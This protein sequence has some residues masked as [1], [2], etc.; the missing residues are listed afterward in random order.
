M[1]FLLVDVGSALAALL[2]YLAF[3]ALERRRTEGVTLGPA[4]K[5]RV[6]R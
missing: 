2:A 6:S 5:R 1:G 4:A 3:V